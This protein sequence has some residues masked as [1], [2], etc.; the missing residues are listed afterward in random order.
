MS[1]NPF[2]LPLD[3]AAKLAALIA[4]DLRP[5]CE[6]IEVAG[7]VRRKCETVGDIELVVIPKYAANLFGE[8]RGQ[9]LLDMH[10]VALCGQARLM[11]ASDTPIHEL[12]IKPFYIGSL[13]KEGVFFKLEINQTDVETWPVLL[14]IKT[15][16]AEFSHRLVSHSD[17][18]VRGFLPR[19][20]RIAEGWRVWNDK[21]ERVR[22]ESERDF[23]EQFCGQWI[24]PE[25]R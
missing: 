10:L 19:G 12:E 1:A 7:S 8:E 15:G 25:A 11:R 5:V 21:G 4:D 17:N 13:L 3:K 14:A 23:I 20:W 18:A 6:R 22:F 16:P 2:R 9:N 24:E